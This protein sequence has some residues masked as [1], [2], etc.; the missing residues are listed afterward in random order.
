MALRT[1]NYATTGDKVLQNMSITGPA[2][3]VSFHW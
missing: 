1:L 2:L 3:G